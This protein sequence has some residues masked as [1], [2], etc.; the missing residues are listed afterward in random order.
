MWVIP[1]PRGRPA[2]AAGQTQSQGGLVGLLSPHHLQP[3]LLQHLGDGYGSRVSG[4]V[5]PQPRRLAPSPASE[6][7]S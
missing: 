4:P 5:L 3:Q 1:V 6:H 7:I 2:P